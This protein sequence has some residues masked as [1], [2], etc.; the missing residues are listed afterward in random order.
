MRTA[1]TGADGQLGRAFARHLK[2]R[3]VPL[4]KSDC[5]L[6][7][8]A[9]VYRALDI[10]RPAI[11]INCAAYTQ[12]D[13]AEHQ[14][15]VCYAVNADG[16]TTLAKWC[17]QHDAALVHISTDYVFG[18]PSENRMPWT[19]SDV[20][21]PAC[22]YA[23]SKLAGEQHAAGVPRHLI[24]R[25]CGLYGPVAKANFVDTMLRLGSQRS[26]LRIVADQQCTPTYV[27]H[28]VPAILQLL[29]V[30]LATPTKA[31][32]LPTDESLWGLY[33]LTNSGETCWSQFAK[34]IFHLAKLDVDV[35][36]ISSLE[37]GAAAQRPSYSVLDMSKYLSTGCRPLPSWQQA[38]A[39]YLTS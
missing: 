35:Q 13:H 33:H 15:D 37:Y 36:E 16:V 27:E 39:R 12:V 9:S 10:V 14:P 26:E 18:Q 22:T 2:D 30:A 32:N 20:P 38:L 11:I 1:V 8:S 31:G 29:E 6:L 7:E 23:A 34:E 19:E 28:L 5:D 21:M 4:A 17:Q 24:I 3:C 25:T